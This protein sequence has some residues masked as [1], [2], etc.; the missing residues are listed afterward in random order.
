[1]TLGQHST[2]P[3][4][5]TRAQ[6]EEVRGLLDLGFGCSISQRMQRALV[7]GEGWLRRG[8]RQAQ[9]HHVPVVQQAPL[10]IRQ[11]SPPKPPT[12]SLVFLPHSQILLAKNLIYSCVLLTKHLGECWINDGQRFPSTQE[13]GSVKA[14]ITNLS[15]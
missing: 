5:E 14:S 8:G 6:A 7:S 1:M 3:V 2:H 13:L 11:P 10:S 9:L 15:W 12:P 4:G